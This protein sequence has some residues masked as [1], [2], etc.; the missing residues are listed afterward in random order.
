[1]NS[2][3]TY[4]DWNVFNKIE[5]LNELNGIEK[6]IYN[7]LE[8]HV[9]N[10]NV[11]AP[12]SNAHINDLKRGLEK[13]QEYIKG[14][15]TTLHRLTKDLLLVQY[16]GNDEVIWEYRDPFDFFNSSLED[17]MSN[18]KTF[19]DLGRWDD[20]EIYKI[21]FQTL[22]MQPL[23]DTFNDLFK[24]DPIFERLYPT[25]KIKMNML[26]L[27][28]D[29]YTFNSR[30]KTDYSL[31]KGLKKYMNDS[32][33]R[34]KLDDKLIKQLDQSLSTNST[35]EEI[36]EI[37]RKQYPKKKT[38]DNEIYDLVISTYYG[39]DLQGF[40][41]DDRF[42]NM[43]DDGLHTFYGSQCDYFLTLDDK[44]LYKSKET[45]RKLGILT[46]VFTPEEYVNEVII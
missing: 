16:Y 20:T 14:H 13:S 44:C 7:K 12:Y 3:Y 15:L 34:L 37:A 30:S 46:K 10:D 2:T 8:Q 26:S 28:D 43:I 40:K 41:S 6:E 9:L 21:M 32:F 31:Y 23:P 1:M 22:E 39:I 25:A 38:M 11:I 5:K 35:R 18:P 27:C 29:I 42:P 33:D 4:L 19:T 17:D 24:A 36:H 45:Y